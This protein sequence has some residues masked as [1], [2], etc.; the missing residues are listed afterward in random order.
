[1][2]KANGLKRVLVAENKAFKGFTAESLTPLV[3]ATQKQFNFTHIVAGASSFGKA[4]LPRVAAKLDTSPI[5]DVIGIKSTDTFVRSIYAGMCVLGFVQLT[6][7]SPL[8]VY[9]VLISLLVE[10]GLQEQLA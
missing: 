4:L 7:S 1:M 10:V 9:T 5:T 8:S 2:S 6:L 3:L